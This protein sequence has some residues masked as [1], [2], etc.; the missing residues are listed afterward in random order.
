[1]YQKGVKPVKSTVIAFLQLHILNRKSNILPVFP[2]YLRVIKNI[3][4]IQRIFTGW[5][6]KRLVAHVECSLHIFD[7]YMLH[8]CSSKDES[9]RHPTVSF[10]YSLK[11]EQAMSGYKLPQKLRYCFLSSGKRG[12]MTQIEGDA[13]GLKL[14]HLR[15]NT[16]YWSSIM[17]QQYSARNMESHSKRQHIPERQK[18]PKCNISGSTRTL[19][20]D[21]Y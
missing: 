4:D 13:D 20:M 17:M 19:Y 12:A 9:E 14:P 1:M 15:I 8:K 6:L 2:I 3:I 18:H 10:L 16:V 7:H 5:R 21:S 11:W